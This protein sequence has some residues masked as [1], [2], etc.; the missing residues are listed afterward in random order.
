MDH[1]V[2]SDSVAEV[3]REEHRRIVVDVDETCEN[4]LHAWEEMD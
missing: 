4:F 1:V 3:G 2:G